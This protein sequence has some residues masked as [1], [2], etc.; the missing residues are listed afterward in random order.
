MENQSSIA[1]VT[2]RD[3]PNKD[4]V[5]MK[6]GRLL[7]IKDGGYRHLKS[8]EKKR[9]MIC[10]CDCKVEKTI[11]LAALKRGI[12]KS[13]GC[14]NVDV[15]TKRNITHGMKGTR[16]YSIYSGIVKRCENTNA[17]HY[18]NYGGRGIKNEF[19]SFEHFKEIMFDSYSDNLT[20]ERIDVNGN[21]S[22][23][24]CKWIPM[25]EQGWNKR[26]NIVYNGVSLPQYCHENYL[27]YK[28][29]SG[30]IRDGWDIEKAIKTPKMAHRYDKQRTLF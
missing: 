15:V 29:I 8:G 19:L 21:Y 13:C 30:R 4:Y 14:Y 25:S 1:K 28:L 6:F 11:D 3:S 24:N 27:N 9:I 26:N 23:N 7:I 18:K 2:K 17:V 12:T 20:I 5:G 16:F 22:P 10:V